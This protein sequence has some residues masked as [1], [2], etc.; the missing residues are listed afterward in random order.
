MSIACTLHMQPPLS[1]QFASKDTTK[2]LFTFLLL[3][4]ETK[5]KTLMHASSNNNNS[6]KRIYYHSSSWNVYTKSLGATRILQ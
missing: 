4:R 5:S 2:L 1:H 6:S 3:T